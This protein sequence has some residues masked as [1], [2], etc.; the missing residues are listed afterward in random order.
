MM[1]TPD[2]ILGERLNEAEAFTKFME[3]MR[4]AASS[5][6]QLAFLRD[7]KQWL[8]VQLACE[9]VLQNASKLA[10]SGVSRAGNIPDLK[11]AIN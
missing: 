6:R 5:A 8:M 4:I 3:A 11:R 1:R 9:G 2:T 10:M 7:Q